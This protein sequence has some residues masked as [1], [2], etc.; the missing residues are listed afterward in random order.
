MVVKKDMEAIFCL[1]QYS[2]HPPSKIWKSTGKF[3]T[4]NSQAPRTVPTSGFQCSSPCICC[5]FLQRW[6]SLVCLVMQVKFEFCISIKQGPF[7]GDFFH[8][9]NMWIWFVKL[10]VLNKCVHP[11]LP[12]PFNKWF[13]CTSPVQRL[14][15]T[16]RK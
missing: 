9:T 7:M 1:H 13:L 11:L 15:V 4:W 16:K 8:M 12:W 3:S 6:F 5:Y 2:S 14:S 10:K